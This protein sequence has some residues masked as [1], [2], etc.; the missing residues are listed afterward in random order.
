M[1]EECCFYVNQ[2][3]I[4]RS[5]V[6]QLREQVIKR[7]EELANSWDNKQYLELGIVAS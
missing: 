6:Q 2:S 1:N 4:V 3:E 5:M 7:R